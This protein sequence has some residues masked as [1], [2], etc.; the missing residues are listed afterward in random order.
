[1]L[2][3]LIVP[4]YKERAYEV[5]PLL[6]SVRLQQGIDF[7]EVGVVI[8]YDG[9]EAYQLPE[10]E[11]ME[12][13]PFEILFL[14]K[15]HGG[16]SHTRNYGLDHA[17][18]DYV[19]FCDA[20]DLFC[21]LCGLRIV[22]DE[23]NRGFDTMTSAFVEETRK[24]G[25]DEPLFV[26]HEQDGTFVHGKI[27]RLAF[28]RENNLRFCD[29][30]TVHED[31]YFHTLVNCCVTDP[32]KGRYQPEKF[33]LWKWRDNSICRHDPD[34]ILKTYPAALESS[35]A[36]V[37]ELMRRGLDEYANVYAGLMLIEAYYTLNRKEWLEVTHKD[38]RDATERR[39]AE[40]YHKHRERYEAMTDMEKMKASAIA[41]ERSI[42][43]GMLMESIS[44][45]EWLKH[46]D[47][48]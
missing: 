23:I 46:I 9:D 32:Q 34:Y 6:D 17:T 12:R 20:D 18:A 15:P 38:Y 5:E 47:S 28:L 22:F 21:H 8:V 25:T 30:L 48:L 7:N 44:F 24:P 27:H 43:K 40:Y 35:D 45:P 19:M 13:Y 3:Q 26:V 11:W 33:Y 29:R 36:C 31:S 41:R 4:H 1:M 2:L 14:H 42:N 39:I 16:I 10:V 37:D